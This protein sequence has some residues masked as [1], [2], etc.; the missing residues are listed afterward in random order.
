M[1]NATIKT[2]CEGA[3][4]ITLAYVLSFFKIKLWFQG[5]SVDLVMIPLLVFAFR[6]RLGASWGFIAGLGFGAIKYFLAGGTAFTWESMLLDY[7]LAYGIIGAAG[8]FHGKNRIISGTL[9][10][11]FSRFFIHWLSGV[12]IYAEYMEDTYFGMNMTSPAV[13]S[14]LYNGS[15]MLPNTVLAVAVMLILAK[16]RTTAKLFSEKVEE[17]QK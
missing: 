17:I 4:A 6:N 12:T 1:K 10:A 13:Y 5:G 7:V 15:F 16:N 14:A 3:I 9:C 11:C 8:L 2:L